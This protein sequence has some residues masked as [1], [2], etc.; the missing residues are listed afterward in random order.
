MS[1]GHSV[2]NI[3]ASITK[4]YV[5]HMYIISHKYIYYYPLMFLTKIS[6]I[7]KIKEVSQSLKII[8]IYRI[9][10][11]TGLLLL[12]LFGLQRNFKLYFPTVSRTTGWY[13]HCVSRPKNNS[14]WAM[15]KSFSFLSLEWGT[16][17]YASFVSNRNINQIMNDLRKRRQ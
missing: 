12:N 6:E 15:K 14:N 13:F 5:H 17:F 4:M 1:W 11:S 9:K 2:P 7:T 10:Q 3:K 8:F 16:Q